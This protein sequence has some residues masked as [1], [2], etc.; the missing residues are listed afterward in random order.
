MARKI[1]IQISIRRTGRGAQIATEE[2]L[3]LSAAAQKATAEVNSFQAAARKGQGDFNNLGTAAQKS[4]QGVSK[5]TTALKGL[6]SVLGGLSLAAVT[7]E[8]VMFA[9][10]SIKAFSAFDKGMREVFTL[11]PG[12]TAA[13]KNEIEEQ[14][15]ALSTTVG[16][17]TQEITTALYESLSA[18][19]PADNVFE[20][21]DVA[22]GAA[23]GGVT[24]LAVVVDGLTS[25]INAY[26]LQVSDASQV[27]DVL[28]QTVKYGKV[29]FEELATNLSTVIPV[30][31]SLNVPLEQVGG[32]LATITAQGTPTSVAATQIRSALLDLS[33][34]GGTAAEKFR[35]LTGQSFQEFLASGGTVQQAFMILA[36]EADRTGVNLTDFFGRI[37]GGQAALQATGQGAILYA[38]IIKEVEN[39][40]GSTQLAVDEFTGS[41]DESNA[42]TAATV[43]SFKLLVGEALQP[44]KLA[45]NEFVQSL[46]TGASQWLSAGQETAEIMTEIADSTMTPQAEARKLALALNEAESAIS[47]A[48]IAGLLM[49]NITDD[50]QAGLQ[51]VALAS[52]SVTA[53]LTDSEAQSQAVFT[54]LQAVYGSSVTMEQGLIRLDG[55]LVG[56]ANHLYELAEATVIAEREQAEAADTADRLARQQQYTA[57]GYRAAATAT[58]RTSD[59]YNEL[60]EKQ[61]LVAGV[62]NEVTDAT[63]TNTEALEDSAG[64][65]EE[66]ASAWDDALASVQRMAGALDLVTKA[67]DA[68]GISGQARAD[69]LEEQAK[70]DKEAADA[71]AE[72]NGRMQ[73]Y[74]LAALNADAGAGLYNESLANVG[75]ST[76]FISDLTSEQSARLG[77]LQAEYANVTSE[78]E[79]YR[80]G[81]EGVLLTEEERAEKMGKLAEQAAILEGAM[82]PLVEVG[83]EYAEQ[84]TQA[85]FNTEAVGNALLSA[86][87]SANV[88][89]EGLALLGLALG[90]VSEEQA[91]AALKA[92]ILQERLEAIASAFAAGDL[93]AQGAAEAMRG[94]IAEVEALDI[95]LDPATDSVTTLSTAHGNLATAMEAPIEQT[96]TLID[97]LGLI[98]SD[99][100]AT[101]NVNTSAAEAKLDSLQARLNQLGEG[102]STGTASG[103]YQSNPD[104]PGRASGGPVTAGT[105]YNVGERGTEMFESPNHQALLTGGTFSPPEN[106]MIIPA[107][108]TRS[109]MDRS[110]RN[111]TIYGNADLSALQQAFVNEQRQRSRF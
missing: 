100:D 3:K 40:T 92:A 38:D 66:Q 105:T 50:L 102:G 91:E 109:Y 73:E 79:A 75:T 49:G 48:G 43:E 25:V 9:N 35:E 32:L 65:V 59:A 103:G 77:A 62:T 68:E 1:D 107:G 99:V 13:A 12:T 86:A 94:A 95:A 87:A 15:I 44:A 67:M 17:T 74:Y 106:G 22:S 96:Q 2:L 58:Y 69:R 60:Q 110:T 33:K 23:R 11:L 47:D 89:A 19:V 71:L 76:I 98:P 82:A 26:G 72:Y 16:R 52:I 36:A 45:W 83:G 57:E 29:R 85:T 6:R 111:V 24:D 39:A 5:S 4:E 80:I 20:F 18:N 93:T 31:A 70:R 28:F 56:N 34:A 46:A 101:V 42:I 55:A 10:E 81:T 30:A 64:A 97:K 7:R 54:A 88:G 104:L 51:N 37:E 108:S 61:R 14:V 78:L 63:A 53:G 90:T 8:V 27:S 41:L 84:T 21:L